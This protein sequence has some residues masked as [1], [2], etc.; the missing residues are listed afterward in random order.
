MKKIV[1][2]LFTICAV[3]ALCA[4]TC[5]TPTSCVYPP[6]NEHIR[7]IIAPHV[8]PLTA[9]T[10][11]SGQPIAAFKTFLGFQDRPQ[12]LH[13]GFYL[14]GI[15]ITCLGHVKTTAPVTGEQMIVFFGA[16]GYECGRCC[17]SCWGT[18]VVKGMEYVV[19]YYADFKVYTNHD[20]QFV[21]GYTA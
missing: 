17:S 2:S 21:T 13:K 8:K 6:H 18:E 5:P 19:H 10:L 14:N 12:F 1:I 3:S 9:Q 11:R 7:N 15:I 4:A 20:T 16:D